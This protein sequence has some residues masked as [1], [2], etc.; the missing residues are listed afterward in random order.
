MPRHVP[1]KSRAVLPGIGGIPKKSA[2][3]AN[4]AP[5]ETERNMRAL[6]ATSQIYSCR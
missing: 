5:E 2:V 4:R 1:E 3:T 6:R